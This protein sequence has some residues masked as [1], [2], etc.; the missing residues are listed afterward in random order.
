MKNIILLL[1]GCA[2]GCALALPAAAQL[3][4]DPLTSQEVDALR[5]S[6]Q[7]PD[8]R[9]K[10]FVQ[11]A[12]ARMDAIDHMHADPPQTGDRGPR[13]HNLLM[14]LGKIVEETDRQCRY[15]LQRQIRYSQTAQR[16]HSRRRPLPAEIDRHEGIGEIRSSPWRGTPQ[17]LSIRLDDTLEAVKAI[18]TAPAHLSTSRK[19]SRKTRRKKANSEKPSK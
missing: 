1:L 4:R 17:G 19:K 8:V 16:S 6:R 15:V 14:D 7:D 9:L 5:E 11:Y 12:R 18:W 2:V 10:L 13:I 3:G